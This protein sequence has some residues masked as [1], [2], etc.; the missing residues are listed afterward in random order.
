MTIHLRRLVIGVV[1]ALALACAAPAVAAGLTNAQATVQSGA[2]ITT[3]NV[4]T[5]SGQDS[6]TATPATLSTT[7]SF[8]VPR[9]NGPASVTTSSVATW[10]ASG[11]SG[12][13]TLTDGWDFPLQPL[14]V[15]VH[16]D[17]VG[18]SYTFTPTEDVVFTLTYDVVATGPVQFGLQGYRFSQDE[19]VTGLAA[20]N[21]IF[22]PSG[23]GTLIRNLSGGVS[24][25]VSLYT[26][27]NISNGGGFIGSGTETGQF[28]F[29]ITSSGGPT[30][31]GVPEPASWAL[32]IAGFGLAGAALRRRRTAALA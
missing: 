23:A 11:L 8:S 26:T 3:E 24:H 10:S 31:G 1:S 7:T 32:M 13:A 22:D 9:E 18:W 19:L 14:G 16:F 28:S 4:T 21:P 15:G 5:Q 30:E 27:G 12:A 25:T 29:A 6:W 2:T 17:G 20:N